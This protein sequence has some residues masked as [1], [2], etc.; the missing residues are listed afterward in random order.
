MPRPSRQGAAEDA[1]VR[2]STPSPRP[3]M[4]YLDRYYARVAP[5]Y[6]LLVRVGS[7]GAFPRL[8]A[9]AADAL[10]VG[11]GDAVIDVGCGTGLMFP[12]LLQRVGASGRVIGID[13]SERM[14]A[15]AQEKAQANGWRNVDLRLANASAY[16][17][18]SG[19]DAVVFSISLSAFDDC[20]SV[21]EQAV[22]ALKA[23]GRLVIL[24]ALISPGPWYH[25]FAN[26]YTRLKAPVVGSKLDNKIEEC[27]RR[28]LTNVQVTR[29]HG[30]LYTIIRGELRPPAAPPHGT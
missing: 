26:L 3:P 23:G 24:D 19:V 12:H 14:L 30:G 2:Q 28:L 25:A 15:L 21:I 18:G 20:E 29:H 16:E 5:L 4:R 11:A 7:L 17:F 27:A 6:W 22:G 10:Q 1:T 8:H 13:S 9:V